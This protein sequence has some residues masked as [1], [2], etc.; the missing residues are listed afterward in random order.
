MHLILTR[1]A[2][3][4]LPWRI[5]LQAVGHSTSALPLIDI[6]AAQSSS[7][8]NA[9]LAA[10][11]AEKPWHAWMFVSS[12]AVEHFFKK[13]EQFA[14]INTA[15]TATKLIANNSSLR[16]WATGPGTFQAL[17]AAGVSAH[18][19]DAPSADAQQFDSEALWQIV[20]P[21]I[22]PQSRVLILR[23]RDVGMPESSRDWL[24]QQIMAQGAQVSTLVVYERRKPA[25]S[26]EQLQS[27]QAWLRDGSVW[28]FSSSQALQNLSSSLDASQGICICTHERIAQAAASRGFA[29]V[30]RSRPTIQDV[31]ASIESLHA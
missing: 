18:Q 14:G 27:C 20:A 11:Q 23:G 4:I 12:N 5:A 15:L 28:L 26:N 7:D 16:C 17:R 29:V 24:A 3:Q 30:C 8:A 31:I 1:P 10:L 13:N 22:K 21:Q 25:F 6:A 9:R 19:I 2:G